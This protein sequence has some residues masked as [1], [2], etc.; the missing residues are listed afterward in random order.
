M[1]PLSSPKTITPHQN[2]PKRNHNH[3]LI[4]P[5]TLLKH[6]HPLPRPRRFPNPPRHLHLL[7]PLCL[8][9]LTQLPAINNVP[10]IRHAVLDKLI[11]SRHGACGMEEYV[12]GGVRRGLG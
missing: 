6:H 11:C 9:E 2:P 3:N 1:S 8:P 4:H 7:P 10:E 5:P 12:V